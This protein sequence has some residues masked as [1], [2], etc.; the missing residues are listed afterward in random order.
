MRE[1]SHEKKRLLSPNLGREFSGIVIVVGKDVKDFKPGDA[2]FCGSSSMGS[3]G[4]SA[5]Y[6]IVPDGI[7]AGKPDSLSFAQAAALPSVGLTALQCLNR[8][9]LQTADKI[10]I[11]EATG[12][13]GA[14]LVKM[15]LSIQF[16][17]FIVTPPNPDSIASLIEIGVKEHQIVNKTT[18]D[19]E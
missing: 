9:M 12:G 18:G 3:N 13:V 16:R 5:E 19:L 2:V 15:L 14:M 4:T 8:M 11:T 1:N 17:N 6:I 7:V 10:P